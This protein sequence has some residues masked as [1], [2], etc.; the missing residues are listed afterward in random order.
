MGTSLGPLPTTRLLRA[1]LL[2][3]P[4]AVLSLASLVGNVL[5]PHLMAARPLLLVALCPRTVHVVVAAGVV[6]FPTLLVVGLVRLAAADPSHYLIGR[7]HGPALVGT[8]VRRSPVLGRLASR[9]LAVE[10]RHLLLAVAASPTGKILMVAGAAGLSPARVAAAD[11]AGTVAQ[12]TVLYATGRPLMDALHLSSG[13]LTALGSATVVAFAA[14][15]AVFN[16]ATRRGA[17]RSAYTG[18]AS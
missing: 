16:R 14:G 5:A 10:E 9:L 4:L 1:S 8:M 3:A 18:Q 11:V 12:L 2:V 6:P 13:T 17:A 7:R 15:P